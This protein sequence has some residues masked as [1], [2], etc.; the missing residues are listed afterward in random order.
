MNLPHCQLQLI[1]SAT[2]A[3]P[4][5]L[6]KINLP[7]NFLIKFHHKPRGAIGSVHSLFGAAMFVSCNGEQ[8]FSLKQWSMAFP[9]LVASVRKMILQ[10]FL[11]NY[12]EQHNQS[13]SRLKS[14]VFKCHWKLFLCVKYWYSGDINRP[15]E[16]RALSVL[17]VFEYQSTALML[18]F[19]SWSYM[20]EVFIQF[21]RSFE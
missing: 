20:S 14:T 8:W 16:T 6:V 15:L 12:R 19:S 3:C 21:E 7:T 10:H 2:S 13:Y 18:T 1:A 11:L 9:P 4:L 17:I 5:C